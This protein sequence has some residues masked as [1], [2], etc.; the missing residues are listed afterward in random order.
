MFHVE[1]NVPDVY[2]NESRDFQ[3]FARL[4]DI[5]FQSCRFSIDSL[6]SISDTMRCNE[7]LLPLLATKIGFFTD[8]NLTDKSFRTILTAF[9][10][11]IKYKG[12]IKGIELTT[13]LFGRIMNTPIHLDSSQIHLQI[14]TV[15]FQDI[16]PDLNLLQALLEYIRPTGLLVEYKVQ[17]NVKSKENHTV[18]EKINIRIMKE[19]ST[20]E[21]LE[22]GIIAQGTLNNIEHSVVASNVGFTQISQVGISSSEGKDEQ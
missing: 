9:P 8:L 14:I 15:V 5:V 2:T 16:I 18:S 17:S 21:G 20:V 4:Y 1:H 11:I 19:L 13:N 7:S 10:Y 3:L 22:S 6:E 12:S